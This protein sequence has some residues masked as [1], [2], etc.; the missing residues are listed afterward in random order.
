MKKLFILVTT[1]IATVFITGTI[2][3]DTTYII[4]KGDNPSNIAK[5]FKTNPQDNSIH[6][7][8]YLCRH[9]VHH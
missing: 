9:Y 7:R 3:A 2:Y 5:K 1:L 6:N 4:K 8:H